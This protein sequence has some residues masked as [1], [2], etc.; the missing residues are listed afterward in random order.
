MGG[1]GLSERQHDKPVARLRGEMAFFAGI[2][3]AL[4]GGSQQKQPRE[5]RKSKETQGNATGVDKHKPGA[6]AFGK[7]Y[8]AG[9][10]R[11]FIF[12]CA[13]WSSLEARAPERQP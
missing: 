8:L 10:K 1:A 13:R 6:A 4:F 5:L 7:V 2:K 3:Q 11:A 9:R 12:H